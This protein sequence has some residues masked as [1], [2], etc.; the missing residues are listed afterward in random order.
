M[1]CRKEFPTSFSNFLPFLSY[2]IFPLTY[3]H[4]LWTF[5][6]SH[7]L[8]TLCDLLFFCVLHA[9]LL[10]YR[11]CTSFYTYLLHQIYECM[12]KWKFPI[13]AGFISKLC[14]TWYNISKD[15]I[16]NMLDGFYWIWGG[17]SHTFNV[18]CCS[19]NPYKVCGKVYA[20]ESVFRKAAGFRR[21]VKTLQ[22]FFS[23]RFFR[24]NIL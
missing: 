20:K 18:I 3:L 13:F 10:S 1:V 15:L 6:S 12:T 19:E 14:N 21:E 7:A 24:V 5:I 16:I 2:V 17:C 11:T 22:V 23:G 4:G 9:F 8:L